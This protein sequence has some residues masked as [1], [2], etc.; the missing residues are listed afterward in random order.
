MIL[1]KRVEFGVN[2]DLD[3]EPSTVLSDVIDLGVV[4]MDIGQGQPIY[5][6]ATVT[7]TFTDGEDDATLNI[8]LVSDAQA[9]IHA[10]TC[11]V[12]IDSGPLLKA[13]LA[14]GTQFIWAL[15]PGQTYEQYLGVQFVVGT[16]GFDA[17]MITAGLTMD[18]KGWKAYSDGI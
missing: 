13:A 5:L 8:R 16:A 6:V 14:A 18:P 10:T 11:T 12:H 7:E 17:G 1:D 2:V 4:G 9:A 15:P 3:A